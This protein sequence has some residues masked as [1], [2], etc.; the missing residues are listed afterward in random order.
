MRGLK[1]DEN[2]EYWLRFSKELL[3]DLVL[4][5]VHDTRPPK[6]N[7]LDYFIRYHTVQHSFWYT[8]E[9]NK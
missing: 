3:P 9:E 1:L 6:S 4:R 5:A 2:S 8:I 7:A